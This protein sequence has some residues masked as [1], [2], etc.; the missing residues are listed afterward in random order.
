MYHDDDFNR[1]INGN[2][3]KKEE[4]YYTANQGRIYMNVFQGESERGQQAKEEERQQQY[5]NSEQIPR[6]GAKECFY[7]EQVKTKTKKNHSFRKF[8]AACLVVSV[9]GG[10]SIGAGYA[11]T[12]NFFFPNNNVNSDN[13]G[14]S[15]SGIASGSLVQTASTQSSNGSAVAI[16]KQVTPSVVSISTKTQGSASYFGG[17]SVPFESK[18]AGSGVIFYQ[19]DEKVGIA[20][21]DHVVEG[22][23]EIQVTFEGEKTVPAKI[24]GTDSTSDLAVIS[25]S[26]ADLKEAGVDSVVIATFGDSDK[27]E[28]G[29]NVIAIGN[30]LGEGKTATSGMISAKGKT[31]EIDGRKLEVIQTDAAI[32]PGNSGGALVNSQ[33]QVIGI[34][35]AKSF[36]SAVE[37][38]GYAIP[39]NVISPIIEK[40]LTD[41]TS[42]KPYLGIVGSNITDDVAQLYQLPIGV[43][44][45]QVVPG[46]S[47]DTAGIEAGDII[48]EFA[49]QKIMT[50]DDLVNTLAKQTIDT[51]VK[52]RII[53]NGDTAQNVTVTIQ[54]ANEQETV[55]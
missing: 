32:N 25:V 35:T 38:M 37:G 8:I 28:V 3:E 49:G 20:T 5:N 24:I 45:R 13:S 21:N 43:L 10:G 18:G 52:V 4:K 41:G 27:I 29:E 34:N 36:E 51:Q 1:E 33:G 39:S 53:K 50:M 42:P 2:E 14:S 47:A 46:G 12:K 55:N 22:A 11:V 19:D 9:A 23:K 17:F 7:N 44:V 16:I 6:S 15:S 40:L 31:I 48:T 26:R 30:A 54:D